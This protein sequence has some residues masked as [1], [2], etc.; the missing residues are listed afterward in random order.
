MHRHNP[1][2]CLMFSCCL[3]VGSR[4]LAIRFLTC[5]RFCT[6]LWMTVGSGAMPAPGA[7]ASG[8]AGGPPSRG[9]CTV[10]KQMLYS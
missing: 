9:R 5:R 2:C 4:T 3:V 8:S 10:V 7:G 1:T 6:R